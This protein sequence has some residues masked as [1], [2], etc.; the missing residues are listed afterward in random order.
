M[1]RSRP[2]RDQAATLRRMADDDRIVPLRFRRERAISITGG[3]GGVGKSTIAANL[4]VAYGQQGAR[5]LAVD[6]DLGMADLNLLMG[7]APARTLVDVVAGHDVSDVLVEA[8]G[9]H[10]LPALNGSDALEHMDGDTMLRVFRAIS[11]LDNRFD[12]LIV[13]VGAGVGTNPTTFAGAVADVVVVATPE[14]LSLAD[15]YASIKVLSLRQKVRRAF[16]LPNRVRSPNEANEV[17]AKLNTLVMRFLEVELVQLP[18]L[19]YDAQVAD[20]AV[21]GRPFILTNPDAPASRAIRRIARRIDALSSPETRD[22][23]V[24]MFWRNTFAQ[25]YLR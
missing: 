20:A 15:A 2:P 9:I 16:V 1:Q 12:T 11:S 5:A 4:A 17:F 7:V 22:G 24:K 8:H 14:P 23:A 18:E 21:T 19:P 13:D 25:E 10:L 6:A 3:K